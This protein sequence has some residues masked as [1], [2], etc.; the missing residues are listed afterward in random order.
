MKNIY[1]IMASFVFMSCSHVKETQVPTVVEFPFAADLLKSIQSQASR[2]PASMDLQASEEKSFRRIYFSSLYHQYVTLGRH[3]QSKNELQFCPQFHHDKVEV[4]SFNV[5]NII[6]YKKNNVGSDE[7]EYFPEVV[8]NKQ[9]S[10]KDY[11]KSIR[12]ELDILCEE[13][14][15]DNY[16]KF[17]NLI[18]HHAGK[19]S[20]HKNPNAMESVLKIPIFANYYLIRML[21]T[22][23]EF[24]FSNPEEKQFIAL[25][26]TH[27]FDQYVTEASRV[28]RNLLRNKMVKR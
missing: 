18:T 16:Y 22:K 15:S 5:P 13:G 9:F 12:R 2:A 19:T 4:D 17:D 26:Q 3:T 27:W 7:R 28:R 23:N 6:V 21:E 14:I 25:T 10:L 24:A 8:F 20:F 1:W 11:E